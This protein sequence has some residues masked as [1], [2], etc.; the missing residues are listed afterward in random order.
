MSSSS[1]PDLEGFTPRWLLLAD[2]ND[3]RKRVQV[4]QRFVNAVRV[5]ICRN[6]AQAR[7]RK[8]RVLAGEG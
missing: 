4:L 3:L 5:V 2:S 1:Y 7:L 6:R 8:L